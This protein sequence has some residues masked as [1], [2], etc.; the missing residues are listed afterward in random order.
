MFTG[1]GSFFILLSPSLQVSLDHFPLFLLLYDHADKFPP[2]REHRNM[3]KLQ[4]SRRHD[5]SKQ[6]PKRPRRV[7]SKQYDDVSRANSLQVRVAKA[8]AYAQL[9]WPHVC[10]L[11]E[12]GHGWKATAA[13]LNKLYIPTRRGKEWDS[14][15]VRLI[16]KR[17]DWKRS[18]ASSLP[19]ADDQEATLSDHEDIT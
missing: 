19:V 4:P 13:A 18:L 9:V 2:N 17:M 16:A 15:A 1:T 6:Q 7:G 8:Q 14:R 11:L 5:A 10:R 12:S 3:P